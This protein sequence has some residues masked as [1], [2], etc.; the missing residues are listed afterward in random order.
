MQGRPGNGPAAPRDHSVSTRRG[1]A[2]ALRRA[3]ALAVLAALALWMGTGPALAKVFSPETFTLANGLQVVVVTNHRVPVVTHMVWYKIG[4]ADEA[5]GETGLAHFL[6]HLMFKGTTTLAP[7]EFSHVVAVNGGED[8]A[9]TT[10]DYTAYFERV[11]RDRL[12]VVMRMEADRMANLRLRDDIVLPERDVVLEERRSRIE[13][14]P[15]ALLGEAMSSALY[16]NLPY[17]NPVIGWNH[18]IQELTTEKAIAFYRQFYAPNNAVLVVAGDITAAELRPLAEKYFG[19]IPRRD[20]RPRMRPQEPEH[21]AAASVTLKDP[22]VG[23]PAWVRDY[24][25][26]SYREGET[27]LAYPLQVLAELLGGG[28]SSR[29]YRSLV[30]D[31]KLAAGAGSYYDPSRWDLGEFSVHVSP[32]PGVDLARIDEAVDAEFARLLSDPIPE[33]EVERAKKRL[34]AEAVYA[35]DSMASAARIFGTA[36]TTG[37]TVED[38]E[39]WPDRIAAVTANDVEAA[40]RKVL[41]LRDSV[42]GKLIPGPAS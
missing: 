31:Q 39:A 22:R 1:P 8:N 38:V 35:R 30:V 5:P 21:H 6:E 24:L 25:A 26:P 23:Q 2:R 33:D 19:P 7:G 3:S 14:N 9:F 29:L 4:A 13:N 28:T 17:R 12:E 34:L 10:Q 11:A 42:T 20:V 18:E 40:A 37:S 36:L 41:V 32:R 15:G 27:A 16:L